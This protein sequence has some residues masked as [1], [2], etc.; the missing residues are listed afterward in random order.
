MA[1]HNGSVLAFEARL[2][3]DDRLPLPGRAVIQREQVAEE[4]SDVVEH[5]AVMRRERGFFPLLVEIQV[6]AD[7][8]AFVNRSADDGGDPVEFERTFRFPRGVP[9]GVVHQHRGALLP[10]P[11]DG[12]A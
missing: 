2:K 8:F 3:A 10:R 12:P 11:D 4:R 1:S 6:A 7:I 5:F 9:V